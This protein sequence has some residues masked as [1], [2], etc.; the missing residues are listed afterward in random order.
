M[1][2]VPIGRKPD[3]RRPPLITLLLVL[4]NCFVFLGPQRSDEQAIDRAMAYYVKSDLPRLEFPRYLAF[5]SQDERGGDAEEFERVERGLGAYPAAML[6]QHDRKFRQ[7]LRAGL[8][9]RPDEAEYAGWRHQRSEFER[10]WGHPTTETYAFDTADPRPAQF[11]GHL[12]LHASLGH[13]L[14]NMLI[15]LLVGYIVEEL[16][17]KLRYLAFYLAGGVGAAGLFWLAD[18]GPGATLVGASGAIS[19]VMGMYTVLFGLRRIEFFYSVLFYFD[20]AKAPA[21]A[22]LPF[23]LA[24]EL[25]QMWTLPYS[26]VAYAAH[27]GGL[28]SGAALVCLLG[29]RARQ[30][31]AEEVPAAVD[32]DER[33]A[34]FARAEGLLLKLQFDRAREAWGRLA[35]K[36]PAE[37]RALAQFYTLAKP[38]PGSEDYQRAAALIFRLEDL[39]G[40]TL[41][42]QAE[43]YGEYVKIARPIRL[44]EPQLLR[45]AE[46]FA[47]HGR[48]REGEQ[49][50]RVLLR[51][52]ADD[53][54]LPPLLFKL[55]KAFRVGGEPE[56]ARDCAKQL[57]ERFP[58]SHEAQLLGNAR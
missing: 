29:G 9:V 13:L 45:L 18:G 5:L 56:R 25:Y 28:I 22:L 2:I 40:A 19:A 16:L 23:W 1:F 17:G 21:I 57:I 20:I 32:P 38:Q 6:L 53:P 3:W 41:A 10:R 55:A 44:S 50:L 52:L 39:D 30:A 24:N 36:H 12:F 26:N 37:R 34:E 46:R 35:E 33:D 14:G 58:Q 27:I 51:R 4:I 42:L 49:V 8:I 11:V 47:A 48:P 31:V 7:A 43:T 54:A 15:L